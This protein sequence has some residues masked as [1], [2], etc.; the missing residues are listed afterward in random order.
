MNESTKTKKALRGSLFAL[1]LCIVLLIGTTFAW[2]TDTANTGVNKIQSGKLDVELEYSTDMTNWKTATSTTKLF[3]DK[4]LWEPGVT[5]VVYLRVKNNGN[6]ALKYTM[7]LSHNVGFS[8]GT[9]VAGEA[10]NVG[11]YLKMG[12][13]AV[14]DKFANREAAWAAVDANAEIMSDLKPFTTD[15]PILEAGK[16][17]NPMALVIYMPTSV[18]NEANAGTKASYV[19]RLGVEVNATQ[20]PVENDS[21]NNEY[22][23]NATTTFYAE[24]ASS[25][26]HEITKNIQANGRYGVVQAERNAQYTIDA[27]LYAVYTK[28]GGLGAA[29]AVSAAGNSTVTI[30][31]GNFRQVGVPADDPCDLIYADG[32]AQ[33]E[34]NGGTF[35]ATQ[36]ER[37]LNCKDGSN[38]KIT[39]KGGSFYKYDPSHPTLGDNEVVVA[40]G[41]HVEKS[42]DWYRVVAD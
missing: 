7:G 11:D 19:Y 18:G 6:L 30:N 9:N 35:R 27:D 36:P 38:A 5:E 32:S 10:Y 14:T 12:T 25:G 15:T 23:N 29:M 28:G 39:V 3:D 42:G 13:A 34:I 4:T 17:S 8:A 20:A 1:F 26:T 21:F 40:A 2:F 24:S 16:T 22:D 41:Y 31:G 37:T 33:I